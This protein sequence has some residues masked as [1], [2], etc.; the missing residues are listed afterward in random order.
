MWPWL[1]SPG[2]LLGLF[3]S[4]LFST[5]KPQLHADQISDLVDGEASNDDCNSLKIG[6]PRLLLDRSGNDRKHRS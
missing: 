5:V 1:H 3:D 4:D 6:K 2:F